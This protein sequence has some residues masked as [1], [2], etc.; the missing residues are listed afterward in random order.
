MAESGGP[1]TEPAPRRMEAFWKPQPPGSD[2]PIP[3][4]VPES[5]HSSAKIGLRRR[6]GAASS[7]REGPADGGALSVLA[8]SGAGPQI[9]FSRDVVVA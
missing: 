9:D 7:T 3:M 5:S 1:A 4:G 2:P 8:W 6:S